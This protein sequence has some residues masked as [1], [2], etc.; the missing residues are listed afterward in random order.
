MVVHIKVGQVEVATLQ[1]HQNL[2]AAIELTQVVALLVVIQTLHIRIEPYLTSTQGTEA[3]T[4][5]GDSADIQ[6]G[7]HVTHTLTTLDGQFREVLVKEYTLQLGVGL[8]DN[9]DDLGLSVGVGCEVEHPAAR[10]AL[11]QVILT[12]SGD[13]GY[14]KALD[15]ANTVLAVAV[16]HIVNGT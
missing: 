14:I 9:L 7:Q 2:I 8:Q 3:M 13:A 10:L 1:N 12:I 5:Q 15:I 11:S 4:L 16:H 6:L